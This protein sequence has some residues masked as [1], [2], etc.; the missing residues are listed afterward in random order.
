MPASDQWIADQ[1]AALGL[2]PGDEHYEHARQA[3]ELGWPADRIKG[4]LWVEREGG[5]DGAE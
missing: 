2:N 3:A 5:A 4:L 1:L